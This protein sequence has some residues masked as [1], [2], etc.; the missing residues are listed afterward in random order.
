MLHRI[1]LASTDTVVW[2]KTTHLSDGSQT[3]ISARWWRVFPT[4][5][6]TKGVALNAAPRPPALAHVQIGTIFKGEGLSLSATPVPEGTDAI[7]ADPELA[8]ADNEGPF[9]WSRCFELPVATPVENNGEVVTTPCAPLE[10]TECQ[11]APS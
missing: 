7:E 11:Y 1:P 6:T 8:S 9:S 5:E 2:W 4:N 10:I 3:A